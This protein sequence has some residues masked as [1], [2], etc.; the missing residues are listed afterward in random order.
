MNL[1]FRGG[2]ALAA[3]CALAM[4][5]ACTSTDTAAPGASA[6]P[7]PAVNQ[8]TVGQVVLGLTEAADTGLKGVESLQ[9]AG[10]L[11]AA[12]CAVV[13]AGLPDAA[14]ALSAAATAWN[15]GDA[16]TTADKVAA[17]LAFV[18]ELQAI[19]AS[20]AIPKATGASAKPST[21]T[22]IADVATLL[23]AILQGVGDAAAVKNTNTV[24]A[25]QSAIP[26]AVSQF[27]AD[28]SGFSCGG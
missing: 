17:A 26:N 10:Q 14:T 8:V 16:V 3:V 13:K 2:L 27:Q 18:P 21:A 28:A 11:P 23:P 12:S 5:A 20:G 25:L 6:T 4:S 22:I 9:A 19:A 7:L 24:P 15:V 1:T